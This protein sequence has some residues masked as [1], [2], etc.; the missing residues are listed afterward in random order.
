MNGYLSQEF[1]TEHGVRQGSVLSPCLFLLLMD[2]L[3]QRLKEANAGA[4][5]E[6]I[7]MG[8][9]AHA[10]DDPQSSRQQAQIINEFLA[11]NLLQL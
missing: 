5:A 1:I 11:E 7:Y 8:S 10:D 2:G 3:L 6:G 4:S 9:L